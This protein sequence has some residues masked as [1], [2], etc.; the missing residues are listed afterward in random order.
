MGKKQGLLPIDAFH[1]PA[2]VASMNN[3]YL[4]TR[5]LIFCF[6]VSYNFA[7]QMLHA[8]AKKAR[9]AKNA[10]LCRNQGREEYKD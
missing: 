4:A 8:I 1:M 5:L 3:I 9:T 7:S 2:L 6:T 10:G